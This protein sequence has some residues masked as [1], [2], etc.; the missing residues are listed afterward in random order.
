MIKL[1][2]CALVWPAAACVVLLALASC[3]HQENLASGLSYKL[4]PEPDHRYPDV[5]AGTL[6]DG[7]YAPLEDIHKGCVGFNQDDPT[8]TLDLHA[9]CNVDRVEVSFLEHAEFSV[10]LPESVE[11]LVSQDGDRWISM[12]LSGYCFWRLKTSL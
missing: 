2:F 9:V 1:N 7:M 6:T 11:L 4:Q 10:E 3:A 5:G 8:I 12:G